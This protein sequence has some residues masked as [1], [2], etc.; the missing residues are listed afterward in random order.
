LDQDEA[1]LKDSV[2]VMMTSEPVTNVAL[3]LPTMLGWISLS[4]LH[5][6][7]LRKSPTIRF[8][9]WTKN[10]YPW[11]CLEQLDVAE[12]TLKLTERI[13]IECIKY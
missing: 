2:K 6:Y 3:A 10:F 5:M 9:F 7:M 11:I 12:A 13:I 8:S 4:W 1:P